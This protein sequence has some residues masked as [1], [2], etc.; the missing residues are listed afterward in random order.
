M[1]IEKG[2][3]YKVRKGYTVIVGCCNVYK[4]GTVIEV[5]D[6]NYDFLIKQIHKIEE[7]IVKKQNNIVKEEQLISKQ[8]KYPNKMMKTRKTK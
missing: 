4:S 8:A 6:S 3:V 1:T 5:T 2:K 7:H